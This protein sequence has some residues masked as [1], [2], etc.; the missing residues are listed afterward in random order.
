MNELLGI[1]GEDITKGYLDERILKRLR[2]DTRM[3]GGMP[4]A[5]SENFKRLPDGFITEWGIEY[6]AINGHYEIVRN[7]LK[8]M[9]LDEVKK[10]P[11]PRASDIDP[12]VY[13]EYREHARSLYESTDYAVI[14]Q[15][16]CLGVLELGCW[17]FGFDDFLYRIAGE[18]ETAE[19]FFGK[20]LDYQ[21]EVIERYYS[22]VG[23]Y[24]DC[25]TSGDDFGTQQSPF[26]S[27]A[28]FDEMIAPFF[29]E[30]IRYTKTFTD[31]FYQHHTCGSVYRLIPSLL[32]CGVDILNPIQPRTFE[33]EPERL[34]ADYGDRMAFWGGVDTQQLL[35]DGDVETVKREV[36]ALLH[37][38]GTDGGYILAPAH[39][40]QPDVP[41]ENVIAVYDAAAEMYGLQ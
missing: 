20:I 41:A 21:K 8:G 36:K 38:F 35:R 39:C 12:K 24:I 28:M 1:K 32:E 22:A 23:P 9:T 27:A 4:R 7:P 6:K 31:A 13:D 3:T 15:H 29:K 5:E 34:K 16:P 10:F 17:M 30:R 11:F 40:I 37:I 26:L 33:M 18:P 2:I 19:W 14:A 25:T